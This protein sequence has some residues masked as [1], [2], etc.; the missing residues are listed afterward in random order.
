MKIT[1]RQQEQIEAMDPVVCGFCGGPI[2]EAPLKVRMK[3]DSMIPIEPSCLLEWFASRGKR[4]Q[5]EV[6]RLL[7]AIGKEAVA[8][9]PKKSR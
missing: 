5:E 1:K 2:K 4:A 9:G 6:N 3:D 7:D 8:K